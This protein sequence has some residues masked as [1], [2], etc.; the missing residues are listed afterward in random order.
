MPRTVWAAA[1]GRRADRYARGTITRVDSPKLSRHPRARLAGCTDQSSPKN[2]ADTA[3]DARARSQS[4]AY[5]IFVPYSLAIKQRPL[6]RACLAS[7]SVVP[8]ASG[9][10]SPRAPKKSRNAP[11]KPFQP[12]SYRAKSGC[13]HADAFG[14]HSRLMQNRTG[15][16]MG[17]GAKKLQR[18]QRTGAVRKHIC[19]TPTCSIA[20]CRSAAWAAKI[21]AAVCRFA[22]ATTA[23]AVVV[24]LRGSC[25]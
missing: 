6:R 9:S 7:A 17:F 12:Q 18:H 24:T 14:R 20:A 21:I 5:V 16:E 10:K 15:D 13:A 22:A 25:G 4:G 2:T 23:A 19:R 11:L 8:G 3:F 1:A